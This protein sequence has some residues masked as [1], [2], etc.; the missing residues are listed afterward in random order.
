M[1]DGD[2]KVVDKDKIG[3]TKD[4]QT[5]ADRWDFLEKEFYQKSLNKLRSAQYCIEKSLRAKFSE[6]LRIIGEEVKKFKKNPKIQKN[7]R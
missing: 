6:R 3:H 4:L 1:S 2:L 5:E 7:R